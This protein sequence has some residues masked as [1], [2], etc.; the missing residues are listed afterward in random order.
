[1]VARASFTA[2]DALMDPSRI[3]AAPVIAI[4]GD[5][6]FLRHEVR[7]AVVDELS[8]KE[9]D[10]A[11][12][13]FNSETAVLRDLLDAL[14]ERSLFGDAR[15]VVVLEEADPFISNHRSQLEAYVGRPV[16]DATLILEVDSW[17]GNTRL[18]KAVAQTGLAIQC[19]APDKGGAPFVN[20]MKAW[21]V[22]VAQREFGVELA[23][24]A[25]D[26]LLERL[27]TEP[28]ILYQEAAR[29]SLLAGASGK[30]DLQLVRDQVGGWRTRKTW[31]MIDAAADG[32]A[33]EALRQ[34]DRLIAA[35]EEAHGLFPQMAST[36]RRFALALRQVERAEGRGQSISLRTALERAGVPAF[37]LNDAERQLRQLGRPR[38]RQ[39]YRWLLTADLELKGH[40]SGKEAARRV[41]ETLIVRLSRQAQPEGAAASK[42]IASLSAGGR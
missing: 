37:K 10:A 18:A 2:F 32:R 22:A 42:T 27:P 30:I 28:G 39:L 12:D 7:R 17:P 4:V 36:L 5:D 11:A 3:A 16:R 21:L 41:V 14:G 6:L 9:E 1:M 26:E 34:L 40:N 35:G 25:V 24:S 19:R 20:Q 29:L 31:D 38:A 23:R 15:R 13:V 33:A 8:G